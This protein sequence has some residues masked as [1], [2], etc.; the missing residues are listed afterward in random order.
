MKKNYIK[1]LLTIVFIG[2]I[3]FSIQSCARKMSFETSTVVPA[4]EGSVKIKKDKNK[5]YTVN[6]KVIRLS[7]SKRLNPPKQT[8]VVWMKTDNNGTKNI[9]SMN[10]SSSLFSKTLKS[11]LQTVTPFKPQGFFITAEDDAAVQ[12]PQGI[13]VLTTR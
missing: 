9:G 12:Y 7:E 1:K 4:A 5:N 11:S 2:A 8:Y 6:L 3:I 13:V 10:T